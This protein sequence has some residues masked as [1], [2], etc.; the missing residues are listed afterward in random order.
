MRAQFANAALALVVITLGDACDS[1]APPILVS[2]VTVTPALATLFVGQTTTLVATPKDAAGTPL[3]ERTVTWS[4]HDTRIAAVSSAG[5][6]TALD[7]GLVQI[8][9][10]VEG[11]RNSAAVTVHLAPVATIMVSPPGDTLGVGYRTSLVAT[12]YDS[13]GHPATGHA[14]T[15]TTSDM[16]K[17][18][19]DATGFVTALDTGLVQV[20]A[21]SES[22]SA[23]AALLVVPCVALSTIQT[24][25]LSF[26]IATGALPNNSGTVG[27]GF[28]KTTQVMFGGG[29]VF[30]LSGSSMYVEYDPTFGYATPGSSAVCALPAPAGATHTYAKVGVSRGYE[31]RVAARQESFTFAGAGYEDFVLLRYTFTNIGSTAV[32]SFAAGFVA[33][34]DLLF[35]FNATSDRV[36]YDPGQHA[37]EAV[38]GD[39]VSHPQI[40]GVIPIVTR[41]AGTLAFKAWLNGADPTSGD[42]YY[43]ALSG[44]ADPSTAGQPGDV[45]G[46]TG[47][48]GVTLA[49][50]QQLVIYFIVAAA[51]NRTAFEAAAATARAVVATGVP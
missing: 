8:D 9:A 46:L 37:Q 30:G 23:A 41:G 21:T 49:P 3:S 40:A 34:W 28:F 45:R 4:S 29:A 48:G 12:P 6:V 44:G 39:S 32:P 16:S 25:H 1:T 42:G 13:A 11:V 50:A 33:D 36:R 43:A 27:G 35:D 15:W 19:V 38:E 22:K 17:A 31:T 14:V 5:V 24:A 18:T 26:L 47:V 10:S 20:T 7:S 51:D 2:T